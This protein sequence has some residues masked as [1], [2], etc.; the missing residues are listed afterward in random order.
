MK[1]RVFLWLM[2]SAA[3]LYCGCSTDEGTSTGPGGPSGTQISG[4]LTGVLSASQSPY[5]VT[6]DLTVPAGQSLV[7]E[8]GVELRFDGLYMFLVQGHLQ[9]VGTPDE[10]IVFTSM[11][12]AQGAG[13]FGQWRALV[14]DT[15]ADTSELAYCLVE[16]G[17]VWDSTVRYPDDST[18]LWVNG[19][20]YC[21]NS[22]PLIRNCTIL[23]N[24]YNGIY[25]IGSASQP[26]LYSNNIFENDGDG[27]RCEPLPGQAAKATPDIR[28]S[29]S[30]ENNSQQFAGTPDNIGVWM[31][32]NANGDSCDAQFNLS[33]DPLFADF[34]LQ[35]Y[36]LHPC[37]PLINGGMDALHIGSIPYYVG[38]TELR[39]DIGGRVITAAAN[40][41]YV[42]CD[43]FTHPGETLTIQPGALVLFEGVYDMRISGLLEAEGA[44][45][46][47]LDSVN[48][49]VKWLGITLEE[50]ADPN[51]YVRDCRFVNTSTTQK[52]TPYG[53]ALTVRGI[54]PEI[55]GNSFEN[56]EYAAISCQD[57]AQPEITYNLIS[58]FGPVA[59]NCYDNSHPQ[60]N[61]NIIRNGYGYG[62]L[63]SF[64]SNPVIETNLIL[65]NDLAGIK[66]E[67]QS[68]PTI[69]YNTLYDQAYSG[70]LCTGQ[71]NPLIRNNII[72]FNG[73]ASTWA[74]T[75][76][77]SGINV[78]NSSFPLL[79]YNDVF[80]PP[81]QGVEYSGLTPDSTSISLDPQF[82]DAPGGDFHLQAGS[83]AQT[84]A[85]DG[86]EIGAYGKDSDW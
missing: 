11:S 38:A 5:W 44:T 9:A 86:N 7:I 8:P 18:G 26:R 81:D 83:P 75:T 34:A 33:L 48:S 78:Q 41:W 64:T 84:A 43:V 45:F 72:A 10:N 57:G 74:D 60:I 21:W 12:G 19:A 52:E 53:G 1:S 71:S 36:S 80:Q 30:K 77:G 65:W 76:Y 67:N 14:F 63:C 46:M 29:N 66:C 61:H 20:I 51:S 32:V 3:W 16:F 17:A 62:I 54:S 58:G 85:S 25:A 56:C 47:P 39:G 31:Q 70:I 82:M 55:S 2:L 23:M 4:E 27:I 50:S 40:P 79:S 49:Q 28:Y 22:S 24:G 15:G 68:A 6:G 59:V 13:D 42:S 69:E 35:D 73:S 37:S